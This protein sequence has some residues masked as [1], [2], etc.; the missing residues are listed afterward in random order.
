[1]SNRDHGKHNG[2][3]RGCQAAGNHGQFAAA[4]RAPRP[5][6]PGRPH[7]QRPAPLRALLFKQAVR[8]AQLPPPAAR[9]PG[10]Q[11]CCW[12]TGSG[13]TRQ[14]PSATILRAR[15]APPAGS[16]TGRSPNGTVRQPAGCDQTRWRSRRRS[17][18]SSIRIPTGSTPTASHGCVPST[19]TRTPSRSPTSQRRGAVTSSSAAPASRHTRRASRRRAARPRVFT[20]QMTSFGSRDA[21]PCCRR[22][23][24]SHCA[25]RCVGTAR[26]WARVSRAKPVTGIWRFRSTCRTIWPGG[27]AQVTPSPVST[28]A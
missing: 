19:A 9:A 8:P 21:A 4:V 27:V 22:W 2:H 23:A 17:I 13:L 18:A 28:W 5:I 14:R 20:S 3:R 10:E 24:A 25:K 11:P 7:H 15:P 12:H 6:C 26:S 16:G 1:M